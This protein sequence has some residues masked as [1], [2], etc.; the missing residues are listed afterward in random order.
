MGQTSLMGQLA[1]IGRIWVMG[2]TGGLANLGQQFQKRL[3]V[4]WADC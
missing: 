3:S 4:N 2:P 1:A